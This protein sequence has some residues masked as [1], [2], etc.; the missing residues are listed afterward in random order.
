MI[1]VKGRLLSLALIVTSM[2]GYLEW[3]RDNSMFLF[4]GEFEILKKLFSDPLSVAH[5]FVLMPMAGQ[6]IL[7]IT[8]LPGVPRRL[9][10]YLG[11]ACL[12]LLLGFICII[13]AISLNLKI[14]ASTLP[15]I[16]VAVYTI[17]SYRKSA[18][19]N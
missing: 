4:Q 7:L 3:G 14:F 11:I 5:P 15:F 13:G 9:L 6:L 16:F 17:G 8:L 12:G 19:R 10:T 2:L 18:K 1:D